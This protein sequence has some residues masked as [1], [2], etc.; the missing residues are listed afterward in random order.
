LW[1]TV[2]ASLGAK[3]SLRANIIVGFT[4]EYEK[5]KE[6]GTYAP[7]LAGNDVPNPKFRDAVYQEVTNY[8]RQKACCLSLDLELFLNPLPGAV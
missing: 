5:P 3:T 1:A 2:K 7:N 6:M 8:F 4:A